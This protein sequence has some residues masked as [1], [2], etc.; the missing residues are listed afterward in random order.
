MKKVKFFL[1]LVVCFIVSI[2]CSKSDVYAKV[3]STEV[4]EYASKWADN[5]NIPY[6]WGGGSGMTLE[7]MDKTKTGT[8]CSGFTSAVYRHFGIELPHQSEDQKNSAVKTFTD[9][10]DAVPGDICWW[11]GHVAIYIGNG[12]IVHTNTSHPPNNYIH[13]ADV[14]YSGTPPVYCRMVDDVSKLKPTS[15]S[16]DDSASSKATD[17]NTINNIITES[18]LTG[19]PIKST[20][21]EEQKRLE[22][23][24]RENLSQDELQTLAYIKIALTD[25]EPVTIRWYNVLQYIGGILIIFYAVLLF[26]CYLL[27]YNNVF[28]EFSALALISFGRFRVIDAYEQDQGII[29]P[30]W[31]ADRK[32][33]FVTFNMI[34]IRVVVLIIVGVL[35]VSGTV[36]N[37]ITTILELIGW[38]F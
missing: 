12:K 6:V 38:N 15:G 9:E 2:C 16:S 1:F 33:T 37:W 14:N 34:A 7:E 8:D 18:D 4:A 29:K 3:E 23:V 28:I 13:F 30:G 22:L 32:V 20:L 25:L 36:N 27:D 17:S 26:M 21:I 19:M 35:L 5:K 10:A 31:D 11:D 24:G